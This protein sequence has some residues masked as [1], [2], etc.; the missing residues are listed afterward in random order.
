MMQLGAAFAGTAIENSMLGAAHAAANPLTARFGIVA[1]PGRGADAAGGRSRSMRAIRWRTS[2]TWNSARPRISGPIEEFIAELEVL[3]DVAKMREGLVEIRHRPQAASRRSPGR[4]RSSGRRDS[5]R[6]PIA[7]EDFERALRGGLR[8]KTLRSPFSGA[9]ACRAR[10]RLADAPRR[11]ADCRAA[12]TMPAPAKPDL[13]WTFAAGKPIKAAAAIAGGRVFVGDDD[14]IVHALDFATGKELWKFK[15]EA[16]IEATPLVLHGYGLSSAPSDAQSLRARSGHRKAEVEIRDGRQDPRR[17]EPREESAWRRRVA[18]RSAATI[19]ICIASMPPRA[20]PCGRTRRTITSTARPRFSRRG[21][22]VFGGCDSFIHV[23]QLARRQGDCGRS[24]PTPTSPRP[25]RSWMASATSATMAISS[26]P[27]IPRA[28]TMKWKYR[29]RNFP[30]FSS[31]ALTADRVVIGG[32]DKRLHCLDRATGKAVWTFPN[33]RRGGQLAGDLRRCHR[34]RLRGWPPLLREPRRWQGALG[35]RDRRAGDRLARRGRWPRHRRR[36]GWK[37]LRVS[38]NPPAAR[39]TMS[40]R[41]HRNSRTRK[42]A[43]RNRSRELLRRQLP[44]IFLLGRGDREDRARP[45]R[46]AAEARRAA[47]RVFPRAVLPE[48]L[49][50]LLLPRLHRQERG[51]DQALPRRR[52]RG[53]RNLRAARR[54]S[55]GASRSSSISAAARRAISR[56]RN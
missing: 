49:P 42:E 30:Y 24:N 45:A 17:R 36:G 26:S 48:A 43:R 25:S 51:R 2:A 46:S 11:P 13:A 53:I 15:T 29:D 1:R 47:G 28:A 21:E 23:L 12:R 4:P 16:S 40:S 39:K 9:G 52:H 32:R 38:A 18:A 54:S 55:A 3:L 6:G 27:S 10:R 37:S 44:A 8:M 19:R 34:R 31:A 33:A 20:R 14:G 35:L 56:S 41:S 50:L 22:I 7:A 5:I